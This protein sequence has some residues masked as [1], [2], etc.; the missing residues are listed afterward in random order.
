MVAPVQ[1]AQV[2]A[3]FSAATGLINGGQVLGANWSGMVRQSVKKTHGGT[4]QW[5]EYE[6]S[7]RADA[8]SVTLRMKLDPAQDP[9][10]FM[11]SATGTL[12]IVTP[13]GQN[14]WQ[15]GAFID[16][17]GFSTEL[18]DHIEADVKFKL[19]GAPATAT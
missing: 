15:C 3:T 7:F 10:T 13:A 8:G 1:G 18:E 9:A 11:H 19:T 12:V 2:Q 4:G 5:E 17:V 16:D 6:P 14:N